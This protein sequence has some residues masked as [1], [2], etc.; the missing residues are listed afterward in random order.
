MAT[1]LSEEDKA[2]LKFLGLGPDRV[3]PDTWGKDHHRLLRAHFIDKQLRWVLMTSCIVLYVACGKTN[4]RV[5]LAA[6]ATTCYNICVTSFKC[7]TSI[8]VV[9]TVT[10]T[11]DLQLQ[12]RYSY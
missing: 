10:M 1:T 11:L 12:Q 5:L 2:L 6:L 9:Q 4:V 3:A 7:F 8:S